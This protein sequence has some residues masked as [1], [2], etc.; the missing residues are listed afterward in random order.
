[1]YHFSLFS[2]PL[3]AALSLVATVGCKA[4]IP[5]AGTAIQDPALVRKIEVEVRSQFNIPS[6]YDVKVGTRSPS[7]LPGFDALT[8]TISH[9]G[10]ANTS[11]FLISKDNNTLARMEKFDLNNIAG[12]HIPVDNR[13]I[14]GNPDAKVTVI[15]F[16]DLECP[17]C[18]RMHQQLFPE[19]LEHYKGK[20]RFIYKDDPLV[21]IHP[22]ALHAAINANCI[23]AQNGNAYWGYVDYLHAHGQEVT[24]PDRDVKKSYETLDKIA[25]EQGK[26][27][28]LDSAK[29]D[30]CVQKQ[31]ETVVRASM[32]EAEDLGIEGTPYLFIDGEHIDG[33]Q[34]LPQVWAAI[35]RALRAA[36]VEPP[37]AESPSAPAPTL[38]H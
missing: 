2:A 16:D 30:A 32:K 31:D 8:I 28:K 10:N 15:T 4:Q 33:A 36:G 9:N 26:I 20:V 7:D 18:A 25:R 1:M 12:Q 29:L 34:P 11:H 19:T 24:G 37:P 27:F 38:G 14:R 6:E 13:P 3:L 21:E 5:P 23:A 35:D 22:W 17:Y